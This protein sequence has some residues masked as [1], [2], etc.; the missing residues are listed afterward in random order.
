ME[1]FDLKKFAKLA[2]AKKIFIILIMIVSLGVGYF[3]SYMCVIPKYRSTTSFLLAQLSDEKSEDENQVADL[4]MTS[5]LIQPYISLL[6]S[7][8][9]VSKV[10]DNLGLNMSVTTIKGMMNITQENQAMIVLSVSNENA[11]LAET[12]AKELNLEEEDRKLAL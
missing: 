9:V 2:W 11:E 8:R 7:K 10:I 12:I 3:Y 1:E 4:S 5:T 6:G